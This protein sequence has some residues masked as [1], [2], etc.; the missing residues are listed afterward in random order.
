ML[1][2]ERQQHLL[3]LLRQRNAADLD[4]LARQ[5]EVSGSTVRRDLET[6]EQQGLVERTHGGAV[7]RG[8]ARR[9]SIVFNERISQSVEAKMAIGRYAASLVEPNMT[10]LLD[11]GT[12]V[13]YAAQQID[14]RP[15]QIVTNS[16]TMAN[17]F[18][19]DEQVELIL[20]G[21]RL[22][23]RTAVCVGPLTQHMFKQLH[24][25]LLLFSTAAVYGD[26]AF[27]LNLDQAEIEQAMLRQAAR[28]VLLMDSSK[29]DRK[30]LA[31][32]CS[33]DQVER[34]VTDVGIDPTWPDRLGLQM[35]VA[36]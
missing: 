2:I 25:D 21:G 32:V 29:F 1:I 10:L 5:L 4:W 12:T 14:V 17:L 23:P 35:V 26:E 31:R 20:V 8:G 3:E 28:S 33:L 36:E 7:F 13:Y 30:S 11:G 27:N 24:A 6:L 15:L 18:A 34:I 16:L 19:D 9:P 22:Y